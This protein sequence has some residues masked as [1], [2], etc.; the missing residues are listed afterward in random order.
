MPPRLCVGVHSRGSDRDAYRLAAELVLGC[1]VALVHGD[2]S[3]AMDAESGRVARHER[4]RAG[5]A[6]STCH[7]L[8]RP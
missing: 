4:Q 5:A 1:V 8:A 6:A 7:V 3:R 2:E